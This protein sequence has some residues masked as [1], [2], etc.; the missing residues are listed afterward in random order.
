LQI[1]YDIF[2]SCLLYVEIRKLAPQLASV[3]SS[4]NNSTSTELKG[5]IYRAL[6][7]NILS[8]AGVVVFAVAFPPGSLIQSIISVLA[9]HL[10]FN[11]KAPTNLLGKYL[12]DETGSSSSSNT[13]SGSGNAGSAGA[14][15]SGAK[16]TAFA[17]SAPS[18]NSS[19]TAT[20]ATI[21]DDDADDEVVVAGEIVS[22]PSVAQSFGAD[23]YVST[24]A[25]RLDIFASSTS[26]STSYLQPLAEEPPVPIA[27]AASTDTTAAP[28][29]PSS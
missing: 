11:W 13:R 14:K 5:L 29:P 27:G 28:V 10:V 15:T 8:I 20:H 3:R 26:S 18:G 17:S 21:D 7:H 12:W 22:T 6:L 24:A 9:I 16:S 4:S 23:S 2:F 19:G 25:I 1:I